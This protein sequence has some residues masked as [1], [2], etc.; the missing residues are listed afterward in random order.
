VVQHVRPR[1]KLW[2]FEWPSHPTTWRDP[3]THLDSDTNIQSSEQRDRSDERFCNH[4]VCPRDCMIEAHRRLP[5]ICTGV[6][7]WMT[8]WTARRTADVETAT[9]RISCGCC[10]SGCRMSKSTIILR[11]GERMGRSRACVHRWIA[12]IQTG[13]NRFKYRVGSILHFQAACGG[14]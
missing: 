11:W 7:P 2:L 14:V 13:R 10:L 9:T 1:V 5:Q 3:L 8:T 12:L 6:I 4:V